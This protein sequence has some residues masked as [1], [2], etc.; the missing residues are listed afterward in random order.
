MI[1]PSSPRL[2]YSL[3]L[4]LFS[5][6]SRSSVVVP[7]VQ[8]GQRKK[9]DSWQSSGGK[10]RQQEPPVQQIK[11]A[12]SIQTF[13][14]PPPLCPENG[15]AEM[16]RWD[17]CRRHAVACHRARRDG[18]VRCIGR[19]KNMRLPCGMTVGQGFRSG[20]R[21]PQSLT[22]TYALLRD[23]RVFETGTYSYRY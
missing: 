4:L 15:R 14:P 2:S 11:D 17:P 20:S 23:P 3:R 10:T 6:S 7:P 16:L 5:R 9:R 19:Q 13:P 12:F 22:V 18:L 21:G 1:Q 8:P